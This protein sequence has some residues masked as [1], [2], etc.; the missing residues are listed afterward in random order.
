MY[1]LIDLPK[2][3]RSGVGDLTFIEGQNHIPFEIK[4]VYYIYNTGDGEQR[5]RH[6]YKTIQSLILALHG[7]FDITLDDGQDRVQI[8]LNSPERGL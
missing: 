3:S 6:A 8:S 1:K 7:K 5:G 2:I 4:R